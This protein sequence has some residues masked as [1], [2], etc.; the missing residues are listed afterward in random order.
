VKQGDLP[1]H[2]GITR[3]GDLTLTDAVRPA[4]HRPGR[5]AEGFRLGCHRDDDLRIEVPVLA[6]SVSR[7]KLFD[8]FLALA[9]PFPSVVDVVLETSHHGP[10]HLDLV[11]EDIDKAVLL[12]HL[13]DEEELLTNDGCTGVALIGPRVP[14]ELQ[15]DEHK[16][17]VVYAPDLEPFEA[18]LRQAGIARVDGLRLISEGEHLHGTLPEYEERFRRLCVRLGIEW[19]SNG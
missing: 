4:P 19:P 11:R 3:Y 13:C 10:G 16:L 1:G 8:L 2:L 12:S 9:G 14:C 17:L 18:I 5:L 7:E 6:A 15:F